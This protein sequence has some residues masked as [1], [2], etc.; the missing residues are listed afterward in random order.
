MFQARAAVR[1]AK[2]LQLQRVAAGVHGAAAIERAQC[3]G[4]LAC[5]KSCDEPSLIEPSHQ[6]FLFGM[7]A[8]SESH[9]CVRMMAF[10]RQKGGWLHDYKRTV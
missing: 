3:D 10:A 7:A 9:D 1:I 6:R 4:S 8:L 5:D 2:A